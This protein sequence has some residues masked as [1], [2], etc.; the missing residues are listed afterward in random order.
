VT[1]SKEEAKKVAKGALTLKEAI[2]KAE[3]NPIGN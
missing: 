2:D 1:I 3:N